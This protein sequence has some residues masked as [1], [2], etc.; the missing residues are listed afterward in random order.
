MDSG[1]FHNFLVNQIEATNL[2]N[3]ILFR[4]KQTKE[5]DRPCH[6][7]YIANTKP[8]INHSMDELVTA[9]FFSLFNSDSCK[10]GK[11]SCKSALINFHFNWKY[12]VKV[13]SV[14][15][16]PKFHPTISCACARLNTQHTNREQS[17]VVWFICRPIKT[18]NDSV[19]RTSYEIRIQRS[20]F[21][22][23]SDDTVCSS[24]F[25]L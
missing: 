12:H 25:M 2:C 7:E 13:L 23:A 1:A 18:A 21:D 19:P 11:I 24:H 15:K 9:F 6:T 4:L 8:K 14:G 17:T 22:Q 16:I 20:F 10:C 3:I 5:K